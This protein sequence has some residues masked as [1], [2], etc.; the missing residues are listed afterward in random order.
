MNKK[1]K[2]GLADPAKLRPMTKDDDSAVQVVIETP[3][4]SRNKFAFDA[5]LG[6]FKLKKVLPEG[7]V[8]PYDFGF[9][10]ST[11]GE[12][13]DPVDVLIL[14]DEPA[15]PGCLIECRIVGVLEGKQT[16]EGETYRNDRFI[17]VSVQSH[18]HTDIQDLSDLNK[19]FLKELGTFFEQYHKMYGS[20]YKYVGQKGAKAARKMLKGQIIKRAA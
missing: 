12:D 16:E 17:A 4:G 19:N 7:M 3:K 15:Y 9:V 13:G 2:N 5:K 11:K 1:P 10:P 20:K 14:M 8:F 6:V 18:K